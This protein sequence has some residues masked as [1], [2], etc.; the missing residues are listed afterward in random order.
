MKKRLK[1][2]IKQF[3]LIDDT[4]HK[5]AGGFALGLFL[6]LM[7]GEGLTATLAFSTLFRLNR[8]SALSG[9]LAT[10]IWTLSFIL[11]AATFLG[12]KIFGEN[13]Q[14]LGENFSLIHQTGWK[15]FL[16]EEFFLNIA[17]PLLVG[18]L[19]ISLAISALGYFGLYYLLTH[20]KIHFFE[21]KKDQ[22]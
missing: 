10:N 5:V 22:R 21:N 7:P 20:H 3:F 13:T 9:A 4:P 12:G 2:Y 16:E 17:L 14:T 8:L 1:E 15:F 18:F 19:I 11:P 6:G